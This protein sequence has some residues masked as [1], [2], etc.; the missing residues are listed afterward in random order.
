[1]FIF[2]EAF[3][4]PFVTAV[5]ATSQSSPGTRAKLHKVE[6]VEEGLLLGEIAEYAAPQAHCPTPIPT[7]HPSF[8]PPATRAMLKFLAK[9][10]FFEM[11]SVNNIIT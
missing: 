9:I 4:D 11:N 6:A 2:L 5:E 8:P 10:I 1:M 7:T 3:S